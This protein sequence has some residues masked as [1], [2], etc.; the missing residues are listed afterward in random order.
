MDSKQSEIQILN[1]KESDVVLLTRV[2]TVWFRE[3]LQTVKYSQQN[4]NK[5]YQLKTCKLRAG[6]GECVG[7]LTP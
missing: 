5:I 2:R 7:I 1:V 3:N 4:E 6:T